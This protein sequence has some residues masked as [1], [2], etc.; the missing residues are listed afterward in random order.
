[1]FK[2][3]LCQYIVSGPGKYSE[4]ETI[5]GITDLYRE[6]FVSHCVTLQPNHDV[7]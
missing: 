6:D 1:M 3:L 4:L 5:I 2:H 7:W